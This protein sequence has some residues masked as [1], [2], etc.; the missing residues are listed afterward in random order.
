V[1]DATTAAK[2]AVAAS[3]AIAKAVAAHDMATATAASTTLGAQ[4]MACHTA[5][6]EK[7]PEGTFKMK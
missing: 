4:C 3:Q 7:T 2:N 5:H 1:E 6:R